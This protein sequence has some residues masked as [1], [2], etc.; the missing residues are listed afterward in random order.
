M[1]DIHDD[2]DTVGFAPQASPGDMLKHERERQG[3]PLN[4]VAAALNLRSAV[5]NGLETDVYDEVPVAAYRR[6][7]L[8]AYARLLNIDDNPIIAAYE[9]RFGSTD[10]ERKIAPVHIT[11]PPSRLGALLFKLV[12]VLVVVALIGLTLLWWQSREG[13]ELLGMGGSEPVAVDT[14]DGTIITEGEDGVPSDTTESAPLPPLPDEESSLG[15]VNDAPLASQL[16]A[17]DGARGTFDAETSSAQATGESSEGAPQSDANTPSSETAEVMADDAAEPPS[18]ADPRLLELTFNEQS[19]TEI[20]D[21]GNQRVFSGL[22][23]PG[24][25]ATVEGEPPF[26]LTVGNAT[27]V[28]LRYLGDTV[29][30]TGPAGSNNVARFTLGE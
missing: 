30:L 28:E 17:D 25:Q 1:S 23:E 3:L 7:Y 16:G 26:R 10:T 4:E 15:L 27:G 14:L 5:V 11:R 6:G 19:W 21:A 9:A 8:R 2:S 18:A 24:T 29:D 13:T 20:F 12:T 22:Q